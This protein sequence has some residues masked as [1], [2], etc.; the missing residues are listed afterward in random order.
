LIPTLDIGNVVFMKTLPHDA[1]LG[2][3]IYLLH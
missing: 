2:N 1:T 3:I